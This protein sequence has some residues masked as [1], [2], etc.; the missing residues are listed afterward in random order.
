MS[1]GIRYI[2]DA[3]FGRIFAPFPGGNL[4]ILVRMDFQVPADYVSFFHVRFLM[5]TDEIGKFNLTLS[6][7]VS[8]EKMTR[9]GFILG[10]NM[11]LVQLVEVQHGS[12]IYLI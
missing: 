4:G 8:I 12:L 9:E 3:I 10:G 6:L 11:K 1:C 5:E 7:P 2:S